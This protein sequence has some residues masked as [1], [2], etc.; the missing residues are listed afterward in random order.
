VK[1]YESINVTKIQFTTTFQANLASW[2]QWPRRLR[3]FTKG[4]GKDGEEGQKAP[5][6]HQNYCYYYFK[7]EIP[8][9]Q[10][11]VDCA[12]KNFCVTFVKSLSV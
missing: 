4:E 3:S 10:Y 6:T 2:R 1:S 9:H 12:I 7:R 5:Y 8:G 11:G